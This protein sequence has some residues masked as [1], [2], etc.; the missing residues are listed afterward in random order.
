MANLE[1][2]C[3]MT[4][5]CLVLG[6]AFLLSINGIECNPL[7]TLLPSGETIFDVMKYGAKANGRI[8]DGM[9]I[10]RAWNGACNAKGPAKVLIP[11][12]EYKAGEIVFAGPCTA[13][14]PITIEIQGNLLADTDLSAYTQGAW[15]MVERVDGVVIT[16]GGTINGRG[17]SSW[18]FSPSTVSMKFELVTNTSMHNLNFMDSMGFHIK[19]IDSNDLSFSNLKITAP[20]NSPNTDGIHLSNSTNVNIADS[21]IGTGGDCISTNDDSK[22][23][24]VDRVTCSPGHGISVWSQGKLKDETNLKEVTVIGTTNV[25]RIKTD[26]P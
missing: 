22:K 3:G 15:I 4:K 11:R 6:V 24:I 21:I 26:H 23:I 16:G 1:G 8:D 10:I 7:G 18:K 20:G 17:Q 9:A 12:G 5:A 14:R 13:Q 2:D 19:A 25:A